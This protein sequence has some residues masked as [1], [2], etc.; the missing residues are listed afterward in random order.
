M[1]EK[2]NLCT[3]ILFL[4]KCSVIFLDSMKHAKIFCPI[5]KGRD[6]NN[7][8]LECLSLETA[9]SVK[10]G[11]ASPTYWLWHTELIF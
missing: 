3:H 9:L 8:V 10:P 4:K 1:Q 2:L 6:N 5:D 7:T 11:S